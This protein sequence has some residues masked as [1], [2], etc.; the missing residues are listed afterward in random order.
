MDIVV[1]IVMDKVVNVVVDMMMDM[2]CWIN[3]SC[4]IAILVQYSVMCCKSFA[5]YSFRKEEKSR[6]DGE[7]SI[8][9]KK[10][11]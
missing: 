10:T 7:E 8:K 1:D 3:C 6:K 2:E 5:I 9:T 4:S 11:T